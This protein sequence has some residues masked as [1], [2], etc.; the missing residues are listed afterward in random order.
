MLRHE[1]PLLG[2]LDQGLELRSRGVYNCRS[3]PLLGDP[4]PRPGHRCTCRLPVRFP[5][6]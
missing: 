1:Y 3:S 6:V 5:S 4:A 2:L